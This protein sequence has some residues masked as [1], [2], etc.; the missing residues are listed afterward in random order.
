MDQR[1]VTMWCIAVQTAGPPS[2]SATTTRS[3]GGRARSNGSRTARSTA[4]RQSFPA[5]VTGVSSSSATSCAVVPS[6]RRTN[7]V[8][9]IACLRTSPATAVDS[10]AR[11]TPSGNRQPPV[12]WYSCEA[13]DWCSHHR[14]SCPADSGASGVEPRTSGKGFVGR[15]SDFGMTSC[16][17]LRAGKVGRGLRGP[18]VSSRPGLP[19]APR[20]RPR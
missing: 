7:L 18:A 14:R 11:S 8:R 20:R 1:S 13:S 2:G 15:G 9:R 6:G 19:P 3:S 12:M 16:A 17:S 4:A 10:A 5:Q